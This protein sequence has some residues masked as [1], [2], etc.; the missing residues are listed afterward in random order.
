MST[1]VELKLTAD[2]GAAERGIRGFSR[3]YGDMVRELKR[4]L[5]QIDAF[6]TTQDNA[7]KAAEAYFAAKRQVS[8]LKEAIAAAGQPVKQLDRELAK[9]EQTL[10][11]TTRAF[12][13]Q[14][15]RVRQQRRELQA[16]GVDTR[17]LAGE[18]AR[19]RREMSAAM[20]RGDRT[21]A[22]E[23]ARS[24]LGLA[25]YSEAQSKVA[26]L[27]RDL[28]LLQSTGKLSAAELAI[29]GQTMSS[30]LGSA[31]GDTLRG[32]EANR[33][34][35]ASLQAVRGEL[36]VGGIAFGTFAMAGKR[37]FDQFASFEQRIAEIGTITNLSDGEMSK[38]AESVRRVSRNM[39][40]AAS[41][42]AAA[43]YDILSAG[44]SPDQSINV[45]EQSARAAGAGL[46]DTKTAAALGLSV[47]NA[48][49]EGVEL[50]ETRYDQLFMAVK[51]GVTTF[52]ELANSIGTVLPTA[53]A[54]NVSFGEVTAAIA[55]MTK[56]G[57][58]TSVAT[59]ALRSAINAL[60]A[61]TP[62]AKRQLEEL[63]ISWN[64][65]AGTLE[66]IARKNL[67]IDAMRQIIPD[68]EART[69]VLALTRDVAEFISQVEQMDKA[70]GT[71]QAAYD[72]MKDTPEQQ[73]KRFQAALNDL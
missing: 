9:A 5:G 26:G 36:L 58:N 13:L 24:N 10:N 17:N 63:G 47:I 44:V 64:G 42:G 62:Q 3:T 29:V 68:T 50:L 18:Q 31:R 11:R 27:Q 30:A 25:A 14:R 2:T 45:L 71:T 55:A 33:T 8:S 70:G 21:S 40:E 41:G 32:V 39:G 22:I 52:P 34:W 20:G 49:G 51:N 16:A 46:T 19:L 67:G 57:L 54:A 7:K 1:E 65:L 38:L 72:K 73:I 35:L 56:Q 59:T 6:K 61:P 4:P 48:Y 37:S 15:E 28:Q 66:Q 12:D 23:S 69:A 60:A 53:A 43:L